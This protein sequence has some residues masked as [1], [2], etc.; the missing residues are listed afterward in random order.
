[1]AAALTPERDRCQQE[2]ARHPPVDVQKH[3]VVALTREDLGSAI[4][5]QTPNEYWEQRTEWNG[6][7]S[8]RD[9]PGAVKRDRAIDW[10]ESL[11]RR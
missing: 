4:V 9:V 10:D 5:D 11:S 3:E 2:L 8:L 6:H 1:M 7:L